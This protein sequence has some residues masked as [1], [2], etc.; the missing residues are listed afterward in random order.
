MLLN[1]AV[2]E[3]ATPPPPH[4]ALRGVLGLPAGLIPANLSNEGAFK[5][6]LL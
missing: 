5:W 3:F 4:A 1:V 2:C 6:T